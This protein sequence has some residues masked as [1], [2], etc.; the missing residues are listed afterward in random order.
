VID[1]PAGV[2]S[3]TPAPGQKQKSGQSVRAPIVNN[4]PLNNMLRAVTV[5]QQI[6]T[7]IGGAVS[8]QEKIMVFTKIILNL[9]KQN[10]H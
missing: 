5:V 9:M 3:S 2:K 10:G 8:E 7:E 1:P 4:Q 6:M